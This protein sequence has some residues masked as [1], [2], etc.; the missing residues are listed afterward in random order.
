MDNL[1]ELIND[2]ILFPAVRLFCSTNV[3]FSNDRVRRLFS[4]KIV[5]LIHLLG[6]RIGAENVQRYMANVILRIFCTFN[7]LY[8]MDETNGG[9]VKLA[10][11]Y[12]KQARIT[13]KTTFIPK[14]HQNTLIF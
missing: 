9:S 8:D 6:C 13:F 2:K 12:S 14:K 3:S 7:V 4:C 5:K 11:N 10:K 1:Q